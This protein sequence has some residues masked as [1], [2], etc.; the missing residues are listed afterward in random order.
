MKKISSSLAET[1]IPKE[2]GQVNFKNDSPVEEIPD[3][4]GAYGLNFKTDIIYQEITKERV[5][6]W[7]KEAWYIFESKERE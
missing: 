6:V 2:E 4:V 5:D 7:I 1:E 3:Q